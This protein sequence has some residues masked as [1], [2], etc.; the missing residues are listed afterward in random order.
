MKRRSEDQGQ[1]DGGSEGACS[2]YERDENEDGRESAEDGGNGEYVEPV[3]G[4]GYGNAKR[5]RTSTPEKQE[6]TEVPDGGGHSVPSGP[7][8]AFLDRTFD[9]VDKGS[10]DIVSWSTSGTSFVI[11]RV[12]LFEEEVIP[13]F[14]NH[15]NL[16]SFVRQ[17]NFYG[18]SK[19]K[20]SS[21]TSSRSSS[22]T[23]GSARS[24]P[25][26]T[27]GWWEFKH[28]KFQRGCR[29]L[30]VEIKRRKE[31]PSSA[32]SAV[33]DDH[34]K[35]EIEQLKACVKRT[36]GALDEIKAMISGISQ[37]LGQHGSMPSWLTGNGSMVPSPVAEHM[38]SSPA[39]AAVAAAAAAAAAMAAAAGS[40]DP[41]G[42]R[43][44]D[45]KAPTMTESHHLEEQQRLHNLQQMQQQHL[46][47]QQMQ[48]QQQ[49]QQ[50]QH[51]GHMQHM[52]SHHQPHLQS[53][54][55]HNSHFGA[56]HSHQQLQMHP[57]LGTSGNMRTPG[58]SSSPQQVHSGVPPP[59]QA[60]SG[61]QESQH[62]TYPSH[63]TNP[64]VARQQQGIGTIRQGSSGLIPRQDQHS[65]HS[66]VPNMPIPAPSGVQLPDGIAGAVPGA[67]SAAAEGTSTQQ[68][69]QYYS[70]SPW[71]GGGSGG[72]GSLMHV[73]PQ[74]TSLPHGPAQHHSGNGPF[75]QRGGVGAGGVHY[76]GSP[77]VHTVHSSGTAHCSSPGSGGIASAE[78]PTSSAGLTGV[79]GQVGSGG[80]VRSDAEAGGGGRGTGSRNGELVPAS[81]Q[82][83][84]VFS[85]A[86]AP[87]G[88]T[89]AT[90][91]V[92]AGTQ[93]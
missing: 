55:Q 42:G 89:G 26:G 51:Q 40:Q 79:P 76:F 86:G 33:T 24:V 36:E 22:G 90:A 18:F 13:R 38:R 67:G 83:Y 93:L 3:G 20:G 44:G 77:M 19:V 21:R 37:R 48:Q 69:S 34:L 7:L 70:Y 47:Q 56:Q 45:L 72:P 6:E 17:L 28:P 81:L 78:V 32:P 46:W 73:Y 61:H 2:P 75:S 8:P 43:R 4:Q 25:Q 16:F 1:E 92:T 30:L 62:S 41:L 31:K 50:Q 52:H 87:G 58:A 66:Q 82:G 85:S 5:E 23:G 74:S 54:P 71:G 63:G 91:G 88:T 60:S 14:F 39:A 29:N 49:Q 64:L 10:E 65:Y 68:S 11:K 57:Q 84:P 12:D 80:V 15:K 35:R 27:S 53:P 59:L 9:M